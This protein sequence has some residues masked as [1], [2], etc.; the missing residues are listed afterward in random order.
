MTVSP[1]GAV[2]SIAAKH[3]SV[4]SGARPTPGGAKDV[5]K[6]SFQN[7]IRSLL[8]TANQPQ[9]QANQA[10]SN[11]LSGRT[12]NI[13]SV[14]VSVANAEMSFRFLVEMRNRLTEAY[15]EIMRMQM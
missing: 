13:H 7:T 2:N 15:Q 6:G 14:V 3:G 1:T 9:E 11:F 12:D 4:A 10:V 5:D 8:D